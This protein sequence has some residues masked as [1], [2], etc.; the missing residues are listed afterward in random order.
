MI[1]IV[2]SICATDATIDPILKHGRKKPYSVRS[3][4]H[5]N[6]QIGPLCIVPH[7]F[8]CILISFSVKKVLIAFLN[9]SFFPEGVLFSS[10]R[11]SNHVLA[12]IYILDRVKFWFE[13]VTCYN[14]LRFVAILPFF[15]YC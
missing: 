13:I 14:V 4:L 2:L 11:C 10:C 15:G 9:F 3:S 7:F 8:V 6:L 12:N 5:R 1:L